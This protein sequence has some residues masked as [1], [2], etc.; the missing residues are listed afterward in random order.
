MAAWGLCHK[1]QTDWCISFGGQEE[2][3]VTTATTSTTSTTTEGD[4]S[5]KSSDSIRLIVTKFWPLLLV[6]N[7]QASIVIRLVGDAEPK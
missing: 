6:V 3:E 4:C 5:D 7:F 2:E 1:Y